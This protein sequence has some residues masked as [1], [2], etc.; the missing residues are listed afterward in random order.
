LESIHSK[1]NVER[2]RLWCKKKSI[3]MDTNTTY[4]KLGILLFSTFCVFNIILCITLIILQAEQSSNKC[5]MSGTD[6]MPVMP[7]RARNSS[8]SS[9]PSVIL[10]QY[11]CSQK[12]AI[13]ENV[14]V[15]VCHNSSNNNTLIDLREWS[16]VYPTTN[17]ILIHDYSFES[18]CAARKY[19]I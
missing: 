8:S 10:S 6:R 17:G 13:E 9:N 4:R 14:F 16:N 19:F 12:Y 1:V 18:M 15:S 7:A 11:N 5:C 2:R 3:D